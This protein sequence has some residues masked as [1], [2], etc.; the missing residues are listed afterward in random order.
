VTELSDLNFPDDLRYTDEHQWI[1][2]IGTKAVAGVTDYAQD[3]LGDIAFVD[4]PEVG[5]TFEPGEEYGVVESSKTVSDLL[6]PISGEITAINEALLDNPGLVNAS[7]YGD[8]WLIE[9]KPDDLEEMGELLTR[10]AYIE[11]LEGLA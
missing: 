7:P 6:M 8:G 1:R 2:L 4:L 5:E 3:Q 9:I 11:M 10:G